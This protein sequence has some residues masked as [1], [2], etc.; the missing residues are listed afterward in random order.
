MIIIAVTG[1]RG[2]VASEDR[3]WI[4]SQIRSWGGLLMASGDDVYWRVGDEKAGADSAARELFEEHDLLHC[5]YEADW[6]LP[7]KAGGP[8]RSL[9][10]LQG[11]NDREF[12][13]GRKTDFLLAFP[14][15]GKRFPRHEEVSGTYTCMEQAKRYGITTITPG[16]TK[17]EPE[18]LF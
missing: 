17:P 18:R 11:K 10:M 15:P 14:Q 6:S 13:K 4:K 3:V 7:H 8:V 2:F 1:W 12:Y 5:V 16:Y 9:H